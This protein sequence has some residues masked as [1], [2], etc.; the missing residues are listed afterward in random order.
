MKDSYHVRIR[1]L[2]MRGLYG[3]VDMATRPY[4]ISINSR[5]APARQKVSLAH[6]ML[7]TLEPRLGLRISHPM[8]HV[9]AVAMVHELFPVLRMLYKHKAVQKGQPAYTVD[10]N[11]LPMKVKVRPDLLGPKDRVNLMSDILRVVIDMY[12][13]PITK[14]QGQGLA[15]YLVED[16][17]P[18]VE[19]TY[20]QKEA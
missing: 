17:F 5:V 18:V 1:P 13:M 16:I 2:K 20:P 8:L 19:S 14:R 12:K 3:Y 6:E 15:R 9:L 10:I 7:H 11:T 4:Q